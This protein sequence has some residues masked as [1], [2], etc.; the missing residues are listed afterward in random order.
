MKHLLHRLFKDYSPGF[1]Q[2]IIQLIVYC[3]LFIVVTGIVGPWIIPTRLLYGFHFFIYGNMGKMV[4]FSAIAFIILTRHKIKSISFI[5]YNRFNLFFVVL[6]FVF[7][8]IFFHFASLLLKEKNFYSNITLSLFA[9]F[10]AV[11][12]PT[13][14]ILGVFGKQFIKYFLRQ[15]KKEIRICIGLSVAF[16]LAIFQIWK[17]WPYLSWMVM[18]SVAWMLSLHIA[19]IREMGQLTLFVKTF[20]VRIEQACSGIESI[21][22]FSSLY[23]LIALVDWKEFN[24][25]KLIFSF[26]PALIGL[27]IVNIIRVYI[28]IL[29]GVYFSPRLMLELFHTYLGM[30][31]FIVYF[32]LFWS[33]FYKKLKH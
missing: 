27:F 10:L 29:I 17:L 1:R 11:L 5:R 3:I 9:H 19:P 23:V 28:L 15:F 8:P 31:L 4:L 6:S 25:K 30:V 12:I 7:I 33:I 32:L 21:F 26:I 14:L 16:Y 2:F 24:K 18:K 13:F 20:A 22:L